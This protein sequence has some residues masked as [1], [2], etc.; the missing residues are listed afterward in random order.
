MAQEP[1]QKQPGLLELLD[2][3]EKQGASDAEIGEGVK[4]YFSRKARERGF[5]MRGTFELTPLC[6]LDCK[7][8]Y[9]HMTSEQLATRRQS[10]LSTESWKRIMSQAIDA[11]M[12]DAL[13]TGG[14]AMLHPG[15]DE[16]YLHLVEHGIELNVKTNGLLLTEE[17]V[18][19]LKQYKPFAVHVSLYGSNDEGYERVT[20]HK[21]FSRVLNGIKRAL[22]AGLPLQLAIT[23]SKY[24]RGDIEATVEL[25]ESLGCPYLLNADLVSPRGETERADKRHD[26]TLDEYIEIYKQLAERKGHHYLPACAKDMPAIRT[27]EAPV[28][29]LL[30]GAGRDGFAVNWRGQMQPCLMMTEFALDLEEASFEDCW[31]QINRFT[32]TYPRPQECEGCS[33]QGVCTPCVVL[34]AAG[35]PQ[36]HANLEMCRKMKRLFLAGIKIQRI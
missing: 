6:N 4:T 3:W 16:L 24:M 14:E 18:A 35:A 32:T 7:M 13:L 23:P 34:H 5:P 25:A 17:R 12:I 8:C 26:L 27:G 33:F 10:V 30:C 20:G 1:T 11:G 15:F 31:R 22:D 9:V 21:V 19:F 2:E 28:R 36:G 29:G